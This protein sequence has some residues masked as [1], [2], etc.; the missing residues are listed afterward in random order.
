MCS[1]TPCDLDPTL[2]ATAILAHAHAHAFA[3]APAPALTLTL[4]FTLAEP[5]HMC[6]HS[7]EL[8]MT[9]PQHQ[10]PSLCLHTHEHKHKHTNEHTHLQNPLTTCAL[11]LMD[12]CNLDL[13]LTAIAVVTAI[14]FT[15]LLGLE[16]SQLLRRVQ[17]S[18]HQWSALSTP[19]TPLPNESVPN[20]SPLST[21]FLSSTPSVLLPLSSCH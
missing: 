4:A 12:P 1:Q 20:T 5:S 2:T 13:T 3:P 19:A 9:W 7:H 21:Y 10:S 17:I 6:T 16:L 14:S 8:P 11:T 18:V 15:D